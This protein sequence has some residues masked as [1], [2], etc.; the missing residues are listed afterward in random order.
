MGEAEGYVLRIAAQEWVEPVFSIAAYYTS[1]PRK[2]KRGQAI[3]FLHK[4]DAGDAVVGY[5]MIQ[6]VLEQNELSEAERKQCAM[7]GWKKVIEF[8]YVIRFD[9]PLLVKETFFKDTKLRG[10]CFHGYAL[11]REQLKA[12][13]TQA[14]KQQSQA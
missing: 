5:G 4:T 9:K 6:N 14:E 1:L 8:S 12:I 10:R 11:S 13:I 3:V 7:H 2:W